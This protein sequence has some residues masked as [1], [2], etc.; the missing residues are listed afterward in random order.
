MTISHILPLA[1]SETV[2][3]SIHE[4]AWSGVTLT[5]SEVEC[6]QFT[7]MSLILSGGSQWIPWSSGLVS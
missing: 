7:T 1:S 4:Q 2:T 3:E 5:A 6:F